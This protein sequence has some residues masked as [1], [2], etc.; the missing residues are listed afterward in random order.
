M[1]NITT[2]VLGYTEGVGLRQGWM[3]SFIRTFC[4]HEGSF[5]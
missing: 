2:G 1:G 5:V 4:F 3:V